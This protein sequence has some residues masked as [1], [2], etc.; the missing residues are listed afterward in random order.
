MTSMLSGTHSL[1]HAAVHRLPSGTKSIEGM[2]QNAISLV[3]ALQDTP[4]TIKLEALLSDFQSIVH[5]MR[6]HKNQLVNELDDELRQIFDE[7][8]A[9]SRREEKIKT[10]TVRQDKART[11]ELS[12]GFAK[13]LRNLTIADDSCILVGEGITNGLGSGESETDYESSDGGS[14]DGSDSMTD[15]GVS[16]D[17]EKGS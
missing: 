5:E 6:L 2:L 15:Q 8:A 14:Q 11:K 16:V 7:R 1:R 17:D 3:K 10:A 13:S 12:A 9:L 4:A